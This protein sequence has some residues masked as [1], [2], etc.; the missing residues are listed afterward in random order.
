MM[1]RPE[2]LREWEARIAD[3]SAR[4]SSAREWFDRHGV[5][6]SQLNYWRARLRDTPEGDVQWTP[7]QLVDRDTHTGQSHADPDENADGI[8]VHVG[9][10]RIQVRPGFDHALLA[11]VLRVVVSSC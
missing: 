5:T 4:T 11:Q 1:S 9:P 10:A 6:K 2:L 8:T 3:Y 7:V